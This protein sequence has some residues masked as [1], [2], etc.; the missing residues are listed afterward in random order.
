MP[1][2][3][4]RRV[5]WNNVGKDVVV[6]HMFPRAKFSPNLTPYPIKLETFL[7]MTKIKYEVDFEEP[8]GSKGK[9]PWMTFNGQEVADS[10]ICI[11]HLKRDVEGVD[12]DAHLTAEE[13][14]VARGF[15]ALFEDHLYFCLVTMRYLYN[16]PK[17]VFE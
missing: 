2:K 8:I 7:R 6:L 3:R 13:R 1:S 16:S 15:R 4:E 9:S 17:E 5:K 14:A 12:L 10:H 11:D